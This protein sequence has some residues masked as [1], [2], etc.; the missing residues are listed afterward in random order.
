MRGG[1]GE[2]CVNARGKGIGCLIA[3]SAAIG[4]RFT[5]D[6]C[7]FS[8]TDSILAVYQSKIGRFVK[9]SVTAERVECWKISTFAIA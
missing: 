9:S 7:G 6:M 1:G 3:P 4:L 5:A 8:Q 2:H